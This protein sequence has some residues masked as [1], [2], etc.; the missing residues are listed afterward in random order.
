MLRSGIDKFA[1][2]MRRP[3]QTV[4]ELSIIRK[5]P[6]V[7][8]RIFSGMIA[9]LLSVTPE[10]ALSATIRITPTADISESYTDNVRSVSEGAESDLITQTQVGVNFTADGNRL[11]LNLNVGAVHD[12]YLETDGL[13]GLRPKALGNGDI[14]LWKDHFFI[15]SSVSMSETSTQSD[16]AQSA[17]DRS[18]PTNRTQVLLFDVSPRLVGQMGRMLEA[19]L[20]Y[21]HSESIFSNP[22][23]G[24]S[25]AAPLTA[26]PLT[27]NPLTNQGG[28]QK[29]DDISLSLDTGK[30]FSRISSQL[31]LEKSTTKSSGQSKQT[32]DRIDLV[33]EYQINRQ[34]ALISR[35][36]Y[37]DT[38]SGSGGATNSNLSNSGATGALGV[39][40]KPGPRMDFRTEYG[41]KYG[42]PNLSANLSYKISSFYTLNA[43]F[44]QSV[45]NQNATRRNQLDRLIVGPDGALVDP[46]SGSTRDPAFSNFDLNNG[47]FRQDLFQMGLSGV[48]GRNTINL[49]ADLTSRDSGQ[50][51]SK[52]DELGVNL[53]LSRR[54]QPRLTGDVGFNFSDTLGSNQAT[55][56]LAPIAPIINPGVGPG[57]LGTSGDQ[58]SYG[59]N[60]SL[61]Y[62]MGKALN[63]SLEYNYLLRKLGAG[64]DISEN[65]LTLGIQARF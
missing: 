24:V 28:N 15:S 22:A 49:G 48:F 23:S 14:E 6:F 16:G 21:S 59:G 13:N 62:Q 3:R 39:H 64:G 34:V 31:D 47:A 65:T 50:P 60:A 2:F 54:L 27:P 5:T 51:N 12:Y 32:D 38:S 56:G 42:D 36:G 46:F 19:T 8:M 37:E 7:A 55:T 43:S 20:K 10:F 52:R 58:T 45:T 33:N 18:L 29:S 35:M 41:R 30:Y 44:Q 4:C 17:T 9:C 1:S 57:N 25:A 11:N 63:S 61:S 26:T 40:L 53:N